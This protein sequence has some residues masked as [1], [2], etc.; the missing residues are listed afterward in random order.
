MTTK[1]DFQ[2]RIHSE[3]L[4]KLDFIEDTKAE[5]PQLVSES[6]ENR[7]PLM[8]VSEKKFLSLDVINEV[9]G[10]GFLEGLLSDKLVNEIMINSCN[11]VFVDRNSVFER[12]S[13]EVSKA[14]LVNL[15]QKIA[16]AVGS[17]CDIS[18]PILDAWLTD[19][20]R[21]HVVLPPIAPDGPCITIRRFIEKK[22]QLEQ[23]CSNTEQL[24]II[25]AL[26][27][28]RKNIVVAGATSSGKTTLLNCLMQEMPIIERIV[29]VEETAEL[30]CTHP[31]WV[32]LLSRQSNSEGVG[33]IT[34][35]DLVKATLRMRPD[36]IVV[37]E[38]RG[39]E[40][41]DLMQALNTGHDGSLCTIHAN[42][43]AEVISRLSSLAL[44]AHPGLNLESIKSQFCFGI[45]AI[46]FVAKNKEGQR[47]IKTISDLKQSN[48]ASRI[49]NSETG[50]A[51]DV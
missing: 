21:V 1:R 10:Y 34:I 29:S 12:V 14:D 36:R 45:D 8:S 13:I 23:F 9:L 48:G 42:G 2:E 3:V 30:S 33:Q 47:L 6:I 44:L 43:P 20:S 27:S 40:A 35:G 19:G 38:V 39:V 25:K 37:G 5:L 15:S 51:I 26:I 16:A 24:N 17:R 46:V 50:E 31:H 22:I 49:F 11:Q 7:F 32:R 18:S 28:E 4:A 41:F